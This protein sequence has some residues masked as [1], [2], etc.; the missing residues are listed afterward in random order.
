MN[1]TEIIKLEHIFKTIAN[2]K[3]LAL[4][5]LLLEGEATINHLSSTLKLPY[6][7]AE[8]NLINLTE[9][10]FLIK[11]TDCYRALFTINPRASSLHKY[12][13]KTIKEKSSKIGYKINA[14]SLLEA[15]L[16]VDKSHTFLKKRLGMLK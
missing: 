8:R 2:R 14:I 5:I 11:R 1:N 4:L 7:T 3:R 6:K 15:V 13:I 9:A 12:L 16:E 10:G